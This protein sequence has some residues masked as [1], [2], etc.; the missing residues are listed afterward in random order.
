MI[1]SEAVANIQSELK[2]EA[3]RYFIDKYS[4]IDTEISASGFIYTKDTKVVVHPFN[5]ITEAH[6]IKTLNAEMINLAMNTTPLKLVERTGSVNTSLR[7]IN[8]YYYIRVPEYPQLANELDIDEGLTQVA[9]YKTLAFLG[10]NRFSQSAKETLDAFA[11]SV[12]LPDPFEIT[13]QI[14]VRFSVD[15]ANWHDSYT[16]SDKFMSFLKDEVW[17]SAI[18]INQN[19][20]QS[21]GGATKFIE[22]SDVATPLVAN[23]MLVVNAQANGIAMADVPAPTSGGVNTDG[24]EYVEVST[25]AKIVNLTMSDKRAFHLDFTE[26]VEVD[27]EKTGYDYNAVDGV[28]YTLILQPNSNTVTFNANIGIVGLNNN[29]RS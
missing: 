12:K 7:T 8:D 14:N 2:Y 18:P 29:N 19:I 1:T 20:Q 26:S 3:K 15:G 16:S 25:A 22:L 27:F 21:S 23:K 10:I 11:N 6:I 28:R 17:G 13:S 9:I 4:A 24:V 5:A